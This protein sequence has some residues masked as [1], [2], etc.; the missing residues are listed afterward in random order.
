VLKQKKYN[1]I[2]KSVEKIGHNGKG[3]IK[4]LTK[5]FVSSKTF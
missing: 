4:F 1:S 3:V 5:F 2:G